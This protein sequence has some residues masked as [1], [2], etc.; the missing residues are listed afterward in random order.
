M[1]SAKHGLVKENTVHFRVYGGEDYARTWGKR[2]WTKTYFLLLAVF[3]K[4][5]MIETPPLVYGKY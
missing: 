3:I 5:S 2:I 4:R 1:I